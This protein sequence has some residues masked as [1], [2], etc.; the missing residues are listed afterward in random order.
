MEGFRRAGHIY[1]TTVQLAS[2]FPVRIDQHA[3]LTRFFA[4]HDEL[5]AFH[6][7]VSRLLAH[8]TVLVSYT[9]CDFYVLAHIPKR[10]TLPMHANLLASYVTH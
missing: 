9:T 5:H 1:V 4:R 2:K 6:T 3:C 10:I 8:A 7:R